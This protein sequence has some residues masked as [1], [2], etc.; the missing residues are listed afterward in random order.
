MVVMLG[1]MVMVR[2]INSDGYGGGWN[3]LLSFL[4]RNL[5]AR[6]IH[7]GAAKGVG[8]SRLI[9]KRLVFATRTTALKTPGGRFFAAVLGWAQPSCLV[10]GSQGTAG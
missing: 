3:P 5:N 8:R 2:R 9:W 10:H 1:V 4:D 7:V 6:I